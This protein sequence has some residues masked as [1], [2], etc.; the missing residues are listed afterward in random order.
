MK[1]HRFIDSFDLSKNRLEVTEDAAH[2]MKNVLKLKKGEI[3]GLCDGKGKDALA[4]VVDFGKNSVMLDI[5]SLKENEAE[6][7]K[8]VTLYASLLKHDNFDLLIQKATEVGVTEIIPI[9]CDRT[10]KADLKL[11]RAMRIAKEAAELAGRGVVP[12]V[13]SPSRFS[14]AL[15]NRDTE[16]GHYFFDA[17]GSTLKLKAESI[18]LAAWIGPEGGWSDGESD[19]AKAAGLEIFTLGKQTMRGET[20][21]IVA[22]YLLGH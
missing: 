20:A 5:E 8:K 10:I 11:D 15:G 1:I 12:V 13:R 2:Q 6:T 18:R 14:V 4:R 16:T 19:E 22:S 21:A 3:V 9:I 7:K 17:S